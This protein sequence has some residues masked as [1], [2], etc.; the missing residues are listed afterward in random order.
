MPFMGAL[1]DN[2]ATLPLHPTPH[3]K[4]NRAVH[5][6]GKIS[7]VMDGGGRWRI[8]IN[9]GFMVEGVA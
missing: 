1:G 2:G 5:C 9:L 6:H 7:M 8:G 4:C 3:V